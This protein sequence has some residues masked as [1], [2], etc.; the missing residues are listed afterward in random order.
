MLAVNIALVAN[1]ILAVV[2][3]L[4]GILGHSE[5]LLSDGI[6]SSSDVAYLVVVR[7]FMGL[8]H[9]PADKEHPYGHS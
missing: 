9:K 2:K 1:V 7:I 3:T 4:I 5:A 8:A 6:N